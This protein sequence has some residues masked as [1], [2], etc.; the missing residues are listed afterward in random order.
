MEPGPIRFYLDENLSPEI[1]KQLSRYGIDIIRGPL[2]IGDPAHLE[3]AAAM[4]RV[5]CT[6]DDDSL[7]LASAGAEHA[8]IIKG[9]QN[10]HAI[11]DWVKF[12]RFVHSVCAADEMRNNVEHLF[13]VE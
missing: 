4:G 11:G 13:R 9:R 10:D 3:R 12:L 2:G 1:V 8:G 5:I 6:E 7:A